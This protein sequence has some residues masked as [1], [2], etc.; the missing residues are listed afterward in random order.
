MAGNFFLATLLLTAAS[1]VFAPV[2]A[3]ISDRIGRRK[4]VVLGTAIV[5]AVGLFLVTAASSFA[6]FLVAVTVIGV[7]QGVYL[8]VDFALV[9]QVLPDPDNPTR[10][11]GIMN[12]ANTLP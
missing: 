10:D 11:I 2:A 7:G 8:V 6:E 12:L 5:F 3:R 4:P 1:L 9:T